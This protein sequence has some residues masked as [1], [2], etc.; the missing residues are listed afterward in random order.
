MSLK[1]EI[2]AMQ[3]ELLQVVSDL[4]GMAQNLSEAEDWA[5]DDRAE[6]ALFSLEAA[7]T[8]GEDA[9]EKLRRIALKSAELLDSGK[10]VAR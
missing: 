8:G 7:A 4:G 6:E 9:V 5:G 1:I 2:E 3:K 10:S